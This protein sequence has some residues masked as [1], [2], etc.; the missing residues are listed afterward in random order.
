MAVRVRF[1]FVAF[2][3]LAAFRLISGDGARPVGAAPKAERVFRAA[4]FAAD[5]TPQK[6]PISLNGGMRDNPATRVHDPLHARCLLLDDGTVKIA[7]V[8]C[9]SCAIPR[10]VFDAAKQ[11]A[12]KATGIPVERMLMSATHAHSCPTATAVFQSEPDPEYR[13]FLIERIAEAVV[14]AEKRLEPARVG[15]GVGRDASQVFNR[16]WFMKADVLNEDPFGGKA[17]RVRMNP[18]QGNANNERPSGP[19]D[20]EVSVLS[21]QS[22]DGRPIGL[23]ANYSLHYVITSAACRAGRSRPITSASSPA[24]SPSD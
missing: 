24:G 22:R 20:P 17:D 16:R 7:I 8:V 5:I 12:S 14:Q 6:L 21:V 18:G 9:D 19:V 3:A 10:E 13:A 2:A 23:L 1:V 4:A 15:W 11:R